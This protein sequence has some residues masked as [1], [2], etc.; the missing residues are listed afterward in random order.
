MQEP[1][2]LILFCAVMLFLS[3]DDIKKKTTHSCNDSIITPTKSELGF[4]ALN[5]PEYQALLNWKLEDTYGVVKNYLDCVPRNL[6][7]AG[8][9]KH[10]E[11]RN[12]FKISG[13]HGNNI[14]INETDMM[15]NGELRWVHIVKNSNYR[16]PQWTNQSLSEYI[17]EYMIAT[18]PVD[19]CIIIRLEHLNSFNGHTFTVCRVKNSGGTDELKVIDS[20]VKD[21][22]QTWDNYAGRLYKQEDGSYTTSL[23]GDKAKEYFTNTNSEDNQVWKQYKFSIIENNSNRYE[24]LRN[25]PPHNSKD[26][27]SKTEKNQGQVCPLCS[28]AFKNIVAHMKKCKPPI[29]KCV[30]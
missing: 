8:V 24:Y 23:S 7:I 19:R 3:K 15:N 26:V 30:P 16:G 21:F 17:L 22:P 2:N 9:L 5:F 10:P 4:Q 13:A 14:G 25:Q 27:N 11:L 6:A 1:Y 29:T 20:Q 28:G 18:I 12:L